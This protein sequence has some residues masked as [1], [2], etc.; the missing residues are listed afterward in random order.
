V[1]LE[2][3]EN[4]LIA[5]LSP[6]SPGV[7]MDTMT[8]LGPVISRHINELIKLCD[9]IPNSNNLK[10]QI[11]DL[12]SLFATYIPMHDNVLENLPIAEQQVKHDALKSV[13]MLRDELVKYGRT[14]KPITDTIVNK[15]MQDVLAKSRRTDMNSLLQ[16]WKSSK[17]GLS[18]LQWA[19]QSPDIRDTNIHDTALITKIDETV[20]DLCIIEMFETM[21]VGLGNKAWVAISKRLKA[22]GYNHQL[23]EAAIDRA[24]IL[25]DL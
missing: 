1:N 14:G 8:Q 23:V 22:E 11:T 25:L 12:K 13:G 7:D 18:P 15:I 9:C 20:K 3:L 24:I 19:R 4:H 16:T 6:P 17:A 21:R 10:D 5:I 2:T